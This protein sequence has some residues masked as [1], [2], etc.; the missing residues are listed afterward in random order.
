MRDVVA[1]QLA[2]SERL[3]ELMRRQ[4]DAL[5]EGGSAPAAAL[6]TPPLPTAAPPVIRERPTAARPEPAHD[7]PSSTGSSCDFSL[8]FF[9][10]CPEQDASDKYALINATTEFADRHDFHAVWLPERHFH[11]FGALF[12]SPRA[13]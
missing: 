4:L 2:L 6:P 7:L 13:A 12:P 8:Y 5:A 3:V 11:S 10:D 9:G 1:R